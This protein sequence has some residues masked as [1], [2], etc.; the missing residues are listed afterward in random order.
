M[1]R[2]EWRTGA[3]AGRAGNRQA[4]GALENHPAATPAAPAR[5]QIMGEYEPDDSRDVTQKDGHAPGEP[6]RT[7]VREDAARAKAGQAVPPKA[8]DVTD[9]E[10]DADS[11][12][13]EEAR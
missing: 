4:I 1:R 3:G 6:P 10:P 12:R 7:G 13:D 2:A 5:S 11:W 9:A 8:K